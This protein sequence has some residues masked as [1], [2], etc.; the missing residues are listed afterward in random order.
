MTNWKGRFA[1]S[2]YKLPLSKFET[3]AR[4][5]GNLIGTFFDVHEDSLSEGWGPFLRIRVAIDVSKPLLRGQLVTFPWIADELW[6]EYRYER[7]LDFCYD[8]EKIDDGKDPN[9]TYG[10]WMKGSALPNSGYNQYMQD[11][12]KAGP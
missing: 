4:F 6:L 2:T 5:I 10:P 9:L 8:C 7:L 11:F 1:I 3:L 12:S